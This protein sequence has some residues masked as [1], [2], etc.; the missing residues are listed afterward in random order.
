MVAASAPLSVGYLCTSEPA[1][2][3]SS[4]VLRPFSFDL[5]T[6]TSAHSLGM[7]TATAAIAPFTTSGGFSTTPRPHPPRPVAPT[8][9]SFPSMTLS[10]GSKV[11][12]IPNSFENLFT[13][14]LSP[15]PTRRI[16]ALTLPIPVTPDTPTVTMLFGGSLLLVL[17][18]FFVV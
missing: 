2:H 5:S 15:P 9:D 13:T 1:G 7:S 8:F 3:L 18:S 11:W 12:W 14:T 16:G 17:F 6:G 10:N 4:K